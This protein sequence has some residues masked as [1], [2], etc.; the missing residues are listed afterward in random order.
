MSH[1]E[2]QLAA[3]MGNSR[4]STRSSTRTC[5]SLTFL[6]A[7]SKNET[8]YKAMLRKAKALGELG[9][10]ERSQR[11]LEDIIS[12]STTGKDTY[13]DDPSYTDSHIPSDA[14][15][16]QAELA[17]LRALDKQREK[18]ANNKMKGT[19]SQSSPVRRNS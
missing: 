10:F 4:Q 14:P 6:Q 9:Y 7:L 3:R 5:T 11:L 15:A 2:L 16:A 17:R 1:Q 19:Q 12:K 13:L 18:K 8:N